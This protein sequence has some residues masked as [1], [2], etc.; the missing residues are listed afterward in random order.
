MSRGRTQPGDR[1]EC[2]CD[3]SRRLVQGKKDEAPIVSRNTKVPPISAFAS[4]M[5]N[6]PLIDDK[7]PVRK[8]VA[9]TCHKVIDI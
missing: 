1:T 6:V 3:A 4:Q 8:P 9:T 5:P 2:N 7:L